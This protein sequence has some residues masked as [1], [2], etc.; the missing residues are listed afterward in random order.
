VVAGLI[1]PQAGA[2]GV[3][4]CV[5]VHATPLL[6]KSFITVAVNCCVAV[7][8]TLAVGGESETPVPRMV[9]AA[10]AERLESAADVATTVTLGFVGTVAAA[11]Q[12]AG[13]PLAVVADAIVP[14]P[15]EQP[16]PPCVSVQ[17]TP[18]LLGSLVTVAVNCCVPLVATLTF[19]G[20]TAI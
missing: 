20:V 9:T 7:T 6:L 17:V 1:V 8:L 19:A 15:G 16:V 13:L 5:R 18:L 4:L 2:Q 14:Q 3:P 12:V 10:V 11:V